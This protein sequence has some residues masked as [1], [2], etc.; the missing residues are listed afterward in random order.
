FSRDWSSDV[1]SS[2][3]L[4]ECSTARESS[5]DQDSRKRDGWRHIATPSVIRDPLESRSASRPGGEIG[6]RKGL[7]IPRRQLH[8]GSS[9]VLGTIC[10]SDP[11]RGHRSKSTK[12]ENFP[13]L[14]L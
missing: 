6:R 4:A 13:S 8:T 5:R 14:T 9:P 10:A 11:I 7:K 1:C 3:W 12:P 2:D